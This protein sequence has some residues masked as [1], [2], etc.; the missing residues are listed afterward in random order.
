MPTLEDH[1]L[2]V[3]PQGYEILA[4]FSLPDELFDGRGWTGYIPPAD[5][6]TLRPD[7]VPGYWWLESVGTSGRLSLSKPIAR[8]A[9]PAVFSAW[10]M[11]PA[12]IQR[13]SPSLRTNRPKPKPTP[14]NPPCVYFAVAEGAPFVKIGW[15]KNPAVRLGELQTA[16]PFRLTLAAFVPGTVADERACHR[17]FAALRVRPNGEWFRLEG[18]LA[19]YIKTLATGE[20]HDA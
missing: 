2:A 4:P 11:D 12:A 1:P 10:G 7:D 14:N 19:A 13:W 3:P 6:F 18:E 9:I 17:R 8:W 15:A 16:C 20:R 5:L